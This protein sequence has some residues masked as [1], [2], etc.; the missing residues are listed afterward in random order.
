MGLE[1]LTS[2]K[3]ITFMERALPTEAFATSRRI[4]LGIYDHSTHWNWAVSA[5]GQAEGDNYATKY[6]RFMANYVYV[7]ADPIAE[8]TSG[9]R[10]FDDKPSIYQARAQ[11]DF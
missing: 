8:T 3:Y 4:G 10:N 5:Y 7:D 9:V 2:S 11:I 6:V 1:E